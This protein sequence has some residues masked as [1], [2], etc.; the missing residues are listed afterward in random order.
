MSFYFLLKGPHCHTKWQ[1]SCRPGNLQPAQSKKRC[2]A[3]VSL[4]LRIDSPKLSSVSCSV[5]VQLANHSTENAWCDVG[6]MKLLP[7]VSQSR[8]LS[9]LLTGSSKIPSTASRSQVRCRSPTWAGQL[10][11]RRERLHIGCSCQCTLYSDLDE[12]I[13]RMHS[14]SSRN[15]MTSLRLK[16][17]LGLAFLWQGN[18]FT[19]D[20]S[21]RS[22]SLPRVRPDNFH[23]DVSSLASSSV[24][25]SDGD[26]PTS[27]TTINGSGASAGSLRKPD[28]NQYRAQAGPFSFQTKYGVLNPFAIWYG[29]VA[30]GFG[31]IWFAALT[32]YQLFAFL[33]RGKLDQKRL[34]PNLLN[35]TW[36]ELL[37]FF[38]NSF[39]KIEGTEHLKKLN[40]EYVRREN[41]FTLFNYI[42]CIV[43]L[44][45]FLV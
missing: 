9:L 25:A 33:T 16:L 43:S 14:K 38:T 13:A 36:G 19:V 34:I 41:L 8:I 4:T 35:Q 21:Q 32:T 12:C 24:T 7:L 5:E 15:I 28:K 23:Y 27:K 2:C 22:S 17:I 40:K 39:P 45:H 37:L 1:T 3:Q 11:D 30:I 18:A 20:R 26:L 31:L 42:F 44:C 10:H 29:T 6:L